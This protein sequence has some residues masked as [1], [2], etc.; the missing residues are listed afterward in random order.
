M[1]KDMNSNRYFSIEPE[2]KKN[3]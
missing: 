1:I 2:N 3:M